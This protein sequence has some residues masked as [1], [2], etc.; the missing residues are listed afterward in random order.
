MPFDSKVRGHLCTIEETHPHITIRRIV[1][2]VISNTSVLQVY[3]Y[4]EKAKL[5][6]EITCL[7]INCVHLRFVYISQIFNSNVTNCNTDMNYNACDTCGDDDD[8]DVDGD[9]GDGNGGGVD[10]ESV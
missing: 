8:G 9:D 2:K 4:I 3:I 10:V 6:S 7:R 1:Q 5:S